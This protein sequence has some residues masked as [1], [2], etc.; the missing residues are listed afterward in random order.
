M[1]LPPFSWV[2]AKYLTNTFREILKAQS[3]NISIV[4]AICTLCRQFS[5]SSDLFVVSCLSRQFSLSLADFVVGSFCCRLLM[6]SV[7]IV[8]SAFAQVAGYLCHFCLNCFQAVREINKKWPKQ[9]LFSFFDRLVQKTRNLIPLLRSERPWALVPPPTLLR[10]QQTRPSLWTPPQ[11][12]FPHHRPQTSPASSFPPGFRRIWPCTHFRWPAGRIFPDILWC[13]ET[14]PLLLDTFY[15]SSLH[16]VCS[17]GLHKPWAQNERFCSKTFKCLFIVADEI[18]DLANRNSWNFVTCTHQTHRLQRF[19]H[20]SCGPQSRSFWTLPS[21]T[22]SR[23]SPMF[24]T[25]K[26]CCYSVA[27]RSIARERGWISNPVSTWQRLK[28]YH[29]IFWWDILQSSGIFIHHLAEGRGLKFFQVGIL[30][31]PVGPFHLQRH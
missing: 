1:T 29:E 15:T 14:P 18:A 25:C 11:S 24:H 12:K 26:D 17:C 10:H 30:V 27:N 21:R 8:T 16:P 2:K 19:L 3:H 5:L 9:T 7:F 23:R 20:Q 4:F 6:L 13:S 22:M 28:L 31:L